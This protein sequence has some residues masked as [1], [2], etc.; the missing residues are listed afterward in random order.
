MGG[1]FINLRIFIAFLIVFSVG[2]L[3]SSLASNFI[4]LDTEK[5]LGFSFSGISK[6]PERLS[7][8][9]HIKKQQIQLLNDKVIIN[10]PEASWAS[11]AD[12]N[13]MDP[14]LDKDS[15]SIE[16]HPKNPDEI[17][18]GDII[19]YYST[20]TGK[21]TVHRVISKQK[22]EKGVYFIV[23]GDNNPAQDPEKVRFSQING[24]LIAILY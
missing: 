20:I 4:L 2:W 12:T 7:P 9:D 11:F 6:S 19:S 15:N 24:V 14:F 8:S 10:I 5:P 1:L 21:L 18:P 16:I 23:K 3:L 13:S 17:K 22:D